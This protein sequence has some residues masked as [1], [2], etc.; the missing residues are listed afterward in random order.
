MHSNSQ[1]PGKKQAYLISV[2]CDDRYVHSYVITARQSSVEFCANRMVDVLEQ[3]RIPITIPAVL[4]TPLRRS[5]KKRVL[6]HLFDQ[7]DADALAGLQEA[8]AHQ[9]HQTMWMLWLD[10]PDADALWHIH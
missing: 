6:R 4:I 2:R 5:E 1:S 7:L 8:P 9:L 10:H 3:E